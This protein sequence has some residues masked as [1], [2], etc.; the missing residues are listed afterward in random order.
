MNVA[1]RITLRL[2]QNLLHVLRK[3]SEERILP[4]NALIVRILHKNLIQETKFATLPAFSV[5]P[6]LFI[7]IIA[8]LDDSKIQDISKSEPKLIKKFFYTSKS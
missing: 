4:I 5:P 1:E 3:E 7:K 8:E 6:Y 2:P